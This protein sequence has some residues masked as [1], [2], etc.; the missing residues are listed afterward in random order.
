MIKE[1]TYLDSSIPLHS[2]IPFR[3]YSDHLFDQDI[4]ADLLYNTYAIYVDNRL[5]HFDI[6]LRFAS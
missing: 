1:K 2:S 6:H 5:K 3:L 4:C